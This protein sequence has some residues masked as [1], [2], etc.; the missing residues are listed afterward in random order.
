MSV[1]GSTKCWFLIVTYIF[2]AQSIK[3][4]FKIRRALLYECTMWVELIIDGSM[5]SFPLKTLLTINYIKYYWV[6]YYYCGNAYSI[7]L[8]INKKYSLC[9]AA[10]IFF[11]SKLLG[12]NKV[13]TNPTILILGIVIKNNKRVVLD[14]NNS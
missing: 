12:E 7:N 3:L 9:H 1:T 2:I 10:A 4:L 13:H 14:L 5:A 8:I 6:H 11:P